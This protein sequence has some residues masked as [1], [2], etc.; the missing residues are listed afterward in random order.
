MNAARL[1]RSA[2]PHRNGNTLLTIENPT[3]QPPRF[4]LVEVYRHATNREWNVDRSFHSPVEPVRTFDHRPDRAEVG[5]FL[6]HSEWN[7]DDD[8]GKVIA[9]NVV[10]KAWRH[11]THLDPWR[12]YPKGIEQPE[13]WRGTSSPERRSASAARA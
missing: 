5:A 11:A 9:G 10:D 8:W 4:T 2:R 13:S 12:W 3:A 1:I 7:F 6:K